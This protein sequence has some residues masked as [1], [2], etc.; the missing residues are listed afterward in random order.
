MSNDMFF[1]FITSW[2]CVG[3]RSWEI[4]AE[5]WTNLFWSALTEDERVPAKQWHVFGNKNVL[6]WQNPRCHTGR[7]CQLM[8]YNFIKL[9]DKLIRPFPSSKN[10]YLQNEAM[11]KTLLAKMSF[12]WIRIK[13]VFIQMA[14]HLASSWNRGLRQLGNVLFAFERDSIA[15]FSSVSLLTDDSLWW[16][17]GTRTFSFEFLYEQK[18]S[19]LT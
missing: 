16:R 3:T 1:F 11:C 17:A 5:P 15:D 4:S 19:L 10:R 9:T 6:D 18:F 14:S 2:N 7:R 13:I 12:I 8:K